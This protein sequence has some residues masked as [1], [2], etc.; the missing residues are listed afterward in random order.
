MSPDGILRELERSELFAPDFPKRIRSTH[1]EAAAMTEEARGASEHGADSPARRAIE[2]TRNWSALAD[3]IRDLGAAR[4]EPAVPLLAR[5]WADCPLVPVR[6]AVGHAL[7]AIATPDAR[8]VLSSTLDDA[9][10]FSVFM[11]VRAVF[12]A[13]P[14]AAFDRFAPYFAPDALRRPG[15]ARVADEVLTTFCP[16]TLAPDG[17]PGWAEPRAPE[18]FRTDPRWIELCVRLRAD[19]QVGSTARTALRYGDPGQVKSELARAEPRLIATPRS[20]AHGDLVAR[21]GRGEHEAVWQELR[22]HASITGDLRMEALALG[23]ETMKRVAQAADVVANR[24]AKRGWQALSGALRTTPHREDSRIV[25]R[26]EAITGAPLPPS[27]LAFWEVVGGIDFVWNYQQ[28]AAPPDLD[29]GVDLDQMDPLAVEPPRTVSYLFEEWEDAC[30]GVDAELIDPFHLDLAPDYLHKAD[31]SGGAPYGIELP[32]A[33]ADPVFVN[34]AHELPFVDY[35]RL[36]F[37]WGGFP[38]LER[39]ADRPDVQAFVAEMSR[40]L[41]P[42]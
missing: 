42:F 23:H 27:L 19:E 18:W 2:R 41:E 29:V 34:E 21:Y 30:S 37:R 39:H 1:A 4:Y 32:F 28:R 11:A 5:L 17:K 22:E 38:R 20:A 25:A 31:I 14:F 10:H 12:D 15:G 9:D 6:V 8:A 26:I 33:G 36:A 24:L 13:D 40:D 16:N 7:R 3:C 35:L